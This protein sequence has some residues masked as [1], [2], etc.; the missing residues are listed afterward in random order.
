MSAVATEKVEST[1]L[2]LGF[3]EAYA[4]YYSARKL[5]ERFFP[6]AAPPMSP[7]VGDADVN[8]LR[9]ARKAEADFMSNAAVAS[10]INAAKRYTTTPHGMGFIPQPVLG[11]RKFANPSFGAA[12]TESSRRDLNS[13]PFH[14]AGA[15]DSLTSYRAK[16]E[17]AAVSGGVLRTKAGQVYGKQKLNERVGQLNRIDAA[18]AEVGLPPAKLSSGPVPGA[19]PG[20]EQQMTIQLN[21]AIQQ[22]M[23]VTDEARAAM[24]DVDAEA[25]V[26]EGDAD[27]EDEEEDAGNARPGITGRKLNAVIG[28]LSQ[29]GFQQLYQILRL[30]FV[31]A[32]SMDEGDLTALRE[33][34][35]R[36]NSEF[37]TITDLV[38]GVARGVRVDVPTE[39][40]LSIQA[41]IVRLNSYLTSMA[42]N[43][44]RSDA[45]RAALS[46]SL[47]KSLKFGK[48]LKR[49]GTPFLT[50]LVHPGEQQQIRLAQNAVL[51]E[52]P[53]YVGGARRGRSGFSKR[54]TVRE[55]DEQPTVRRGDRSGFKPT[56][57]DEF[58]YASGEW[59]KSNGR[60]DAA[61][62]NQPRAVNVSGPGY[63][64]LKGTQKAS[65]EPRRLGAAISKR[66]DKETGGYNVAFG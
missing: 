40:L 66:F 48:D 32:P 31:L 8:A 12:I 60:G 58:G 19:H 2:N 51:A 44:N 57:R 22:L 43:V 25:D 27:E 63:E 56:P 20:D 5:P 52:D 16:T 18:A 23:D 55:D 35:S 4:S 62:F 37:E 53:E 65:A 24:E 64:A 11:Q 9:L 3:P 59:Y 26:D 17:P 41:I 30:V 21:L 1:A 47:I 33:K 61:Y 45:E 36:I 29:F 14:Y 15:L 54:G 38:A 49:T 46:K 28:N 6:S 50:G 34:I 42:D 13:A 39:N 10:T 7:Y